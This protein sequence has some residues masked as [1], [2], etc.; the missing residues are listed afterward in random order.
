MSNPIKSV[1]L[2]TD[3][4]QSLK[5][6]LDLIGAFLV[7][8]NAVFTEWTPQAVLLMV[9]LLVRAF[10][11]WTTRGYE[12]AKPPMPEPA[13]TDELGQVLRRGRD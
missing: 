10:L 3:E 6:S 1:A 12:A 2:T 8:G 7:S 13:E 11:G 4:G 5:G 9:F